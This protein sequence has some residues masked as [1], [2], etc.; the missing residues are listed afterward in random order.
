LRRRCRSEGHGDVEAEQLPLPVD[1]LI[2]DLKLDLARL[3]GKEA[4]ELEQSLG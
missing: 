2:H 1:R 3:G 4:D